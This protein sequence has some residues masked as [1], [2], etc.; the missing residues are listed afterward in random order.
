MYQTGKEYKLSIDSYVDERSDPL[1]ASA[2]ASQYMTNMYKIF[3]DWDLVLAAYNSGAGNVSKAIRRSGGQKT[4][5]I[6]K[7]IYQEKRKDM[8]Q[9]FSNNV[10]L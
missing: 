6:L 9:L 8:F 5:G 10:Y 3:G 2:A 7:S 1:K 4:F